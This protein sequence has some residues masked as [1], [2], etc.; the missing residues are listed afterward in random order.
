MGRGPVARCLP[1]QNPKARRNE[2]DAT[3]GAIRIRRLS[4][5]YAPGVCDRANH[6][7]RAAADLCGTT[8]VSVLALSTNRADEPWAQL[9]QGTGGDGIVA[10]PP[11]SRNPTTMLG[12]RTRLLSPTRRKISMNRSPRTRSRE[13]D[14]GLEARTRSSA[15]ATCDSSAGRGGRRRR[16][17]STHLSLILASTSARA[18]AYSWSA[19]GRRADESVP[20]AARRAKP[21]CSA[22]NCKAIRLDL[23]AIDPGSPNHQ[24][25]LTRISAAYDGLWTSRRQISSPERGDHE[26]YSH[27]HL[28]SAVS[29]M[30][31]FNS[32]PA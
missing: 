7:P 10:A 2:I 18:G 29:F 3:S 26:D 21:R 27:C 16:A 17:T 1:D 20:S 24:I 22:A 6:L 8:S 12:H 31:A 9:S 11:P 30:A 23:R 5:G 4:V 25:G 15:V 14:L 19:P 28:A 32:A 13:A